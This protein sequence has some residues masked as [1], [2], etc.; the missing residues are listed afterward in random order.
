VRFRRIYNN[1]FYIDVIC[2][3]HFGL[4]SRRLFSEISGYYQN[5]RY[6]LK[7][8][9]DFDVSYEFSFFQI[10]LYLRKAFLV[11]LHCISYRNLSKLGYKIINYK[12]NL[13]Y[14]IYLHHG[15]LYIYSAVSKIKI[16]E[17]KNK[18]V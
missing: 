8:Y 3:T 6:N 4:K 11:T 1:I 10:R 14:M 5:C 9:T 18:D 13:F 2:Q 16:Y 12:N 7:F 17:S 15:Y